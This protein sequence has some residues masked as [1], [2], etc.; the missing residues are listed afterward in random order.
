MNISGI[1]IIQAQ[2]LQNQD[3]STSQSSLQDLLLDIATS[4]SSLYTLQSQNESF[5]MEIE[6]EDGT[7]VTMDYVREGVVNKTSYEF[8]Q[9]GNYT[10]GNSS[11]TPEN[12]ANRI[13]DFAKALWDGSTEQL[14]VLADA[15][16][17]GV[18]QARKKLGSIPS[19]LDNLLS[20]TV[21]LLNE[22]IAEMKA[23]AQEAA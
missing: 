18:S 7:K 21:D 15:I 4:K 17:E 16:E 14:E 11:F 9:Y 8:G 20:K 2:L 22:G 13:L 6:L 19:W 1:G 23:E 3:S 12:T 5:H 10:Y